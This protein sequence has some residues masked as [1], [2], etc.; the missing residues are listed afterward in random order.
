MVMQISKDDIDVLKFYEEAG[1]NESC[2][3]EPFNFMGENNNIF[4]KKSFESAKV[5]GNVSILK[6]RQEAEKIV[7]EIDSVKELCKAI[8]EFSLN[9]LSKFASN[10]IYG[11]GVENPDLLVIT[12]MPNSDE[13]RSGVPMSGATG[14]LLKKILASVNSSVETNTYT[15]PASPFRAPGA[16]MPT[17]EEMEISIPFIKKFIEI[18]KP[19]IILSMGSLSTNILLDSDKPITSLRG[20]WA[21]YQG[22]PVMPTFA[23]TYLLN[24]RDAKKKTWEDLKLLMQKL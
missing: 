12:E 15:F 22:I 13:D 16:R 19:K 8:S 21:E 11:V 3:G 9:P 14:E 2:G 17:S 1:I 4:E 20:V 18:L 7:S 23:L 5:D 6:A 10:S 24:N